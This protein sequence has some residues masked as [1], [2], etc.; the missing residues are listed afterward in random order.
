MSETTT[1]SGRTGS[2]QTRRQNAEKG[3]VASKALL[4]NLQKVLVDLIEA[5]DNDLE[6]GN[7]GD[8]AAWRERVQG[9]KQ[10]F[11]LGWTEPDLAEDDSPLSPQFVLQRLGEIAG[12][13]AMG[14]DDFVRKALSAAND[15]RVVVTDCEAPYF[16]ALIDDHTLAPVEN[17]TG[18]PT[19]YG[20]WMRARR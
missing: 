1:G 15:H 16:G 10:M 12:P 9:W 17:A 19:R 11:P 2:R 7:G 18:Y 6:A 4:D 13:D 20:D 5:V 8:Y 14:M 3:F